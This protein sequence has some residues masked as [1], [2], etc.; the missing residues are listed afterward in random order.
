MYWVFEKP[1]FMDFEFWHQIKKSL[2]FKFNGMKIIQLIPIYKYLF[3]ASIHGHSGNED[4]NLSYCSKMT[5]FFL[6]L[7]GGKDCHQGI[8]T[9]E[10][11]SCLRSPSSVESFWFEF[12]SSFSSFFGASVCLESVKLLSGT[13]FRPF[14]DLWR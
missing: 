14:D 13:Y 6:F 10:L 1:K 8:L 11:S 3:N 7:L 2:F 9:F 12:E 4:F 5:L